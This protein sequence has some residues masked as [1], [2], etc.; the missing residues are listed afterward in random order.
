MCAQEQAK[1]QAA[2][3]TTS[4]EGAL[5]DNILSQGMRARDDDARQRGRDLLKE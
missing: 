2:A 4:E 5:L 3:Q 1:S